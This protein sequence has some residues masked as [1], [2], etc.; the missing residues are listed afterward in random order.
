MCFL[1]LTPHDQSVSKSISPTFKVYPKVTYTCYLYHDP[2]P[3]LY[4]LSPGQ[5]DNLLP[6]VFL[7]VFSCCFLI[8]APGRRG[9]NLSQLQTGLQHFPA[10]IPSSALHSSWNYIKFF[11]KACKPHVL[12]YCPLLKSSHSTLFHGHCFMAALEHIPSQVSGCRGA[13]HPTVLSAWI[14]RTHFFTWLVHF[15]GSG[16]HSNALPVRG[17][18]WHPSLTDNTS[19]PYSSVAGLSPLFH[20]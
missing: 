12:C 10:W 13:S 18:R 2:Q 6:A 9:R 16:T 15:S 7:C 17:P 4:L 19:H 14:A 5:P 20:F 8:H 1:L 3:S 11:S